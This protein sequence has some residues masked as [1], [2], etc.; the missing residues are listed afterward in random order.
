[1]TNFDVGALFRFVV[2]EISPS[3]CGNDREEYEILS[4]PCT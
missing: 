1:M 4:K 3:R 2:D